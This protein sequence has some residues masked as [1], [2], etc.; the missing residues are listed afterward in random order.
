MNLPA[1]SSTDRIT[2]MHR[3]I[4]FR[5][6]YSKS[7]TSNVISIVATNVAGYIVLQGIDEMITL[8][9]N[10]IEEM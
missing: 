9:D 6:I 1:I 8:M 5:Y 7:I 10:T 4:G 3:S 2:F